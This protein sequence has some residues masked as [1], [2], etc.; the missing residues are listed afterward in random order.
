LGFGRQTLTAVI[1]FALLGP[2]EVRRDGDTL[3]L[4]GYKQRLLL[5]VLLLEANRAVASA[6]LIELLWGDDPPETASNI[7]QQYISQLRRLLDPQDGRHALV[8]QAPGYRLQVDSEQVDAARFE[9]LVTAARQAGTAGD[10]DTALRLYAEAETLWRGTLLA[11]LGDEPVVVRERTR[12]EELRLGAR[13]DRFEIGLRHGHHAD[14]V[15]AIETVAAEH[16]L[17]ER[18][19]GLLMRALYGSG[20]Q[21]EALAVYRETRRRLSD[22]LGI[23]PGP[24]L[25]KLELSVLRHDPL[26]AAPPQEARLDNRPLRATSRGA[27]S[28]A[29]CSSCGTEVQPGER[30]CPECAATLVVTAAAAREERKVITVLFADLVG[31]TSRSERMDPEDV[32]ALLSPY[33]TRV[34][35]ELERFGGTVEKFIGDAVMALFGAPVAH[36]DDPERAVRA[37]LAI[38]DWVVDEQADLQVRIAVNTGEALVTLGARPSQGEGMAS[39]DV[40]NT[41]ARLQTGAPVNGILVGETT[42]RATAPVITYRQPEPVTAKGKAEPVPAWE[43]LEARSRFGVDLAAASRSPLVGRQRELNVLKDALQRVRSDRAPQLVTLVGVPGIGKSRLVAELFEAVD[44]DPSALIFWRQGRSLPYGDGVTFWALAEMVKAQTGILETDSPEDAA[45]KLESSVAALIP[46]PADAQWIE[47]HLRPLAGLGSG[48]EANSDRREEA[49]TAWRRFFEALAEQSPLVLVFEDLHWAD[50]NLLDFVEHLVDWAGSVPLLVICTTRPELFERRPGWAGTSRTTTRL[51][52]APLSDDE[53]AQLIS[54]LSARPVMPAE[55]QQALL[56][57]AG[58][59]PLYAEQYVRML[60][61]R[62][63]AEDLP[64]PE[65]V[66]GIIAARLDALPAEEKRLL[67][68]A[69][70]LGK[71]FWLGAVT[72]GGE[73]ERRTAE[74]RLHVLERKDFVQ[75]ARRSSV[76][77][78]AE[79][80]FLHVLVRDVAYG[81]IPRGD[82][83]EKHRLAAEWIAALGRT[84]DHAEML[85]HHYLSAIQLRHAAGKSVDAPFAERALA[86]LRDAGE[87]AYS[88]DAYTGAAGYY[89]SALELATPGSS[90]RAQLLFKLG[91]TRRVA[92]DVGQELLVAARDALLAAGDNGVAAEAEIELALLNSDRGDFPLVS[93]CIGRARELVDNLE[94]SRSKAHVISAISGFLMI[95]GEDQAAIRVGRDALRMA[96]QLDLGEERAR[97]LS[98]IGSSRMK[99]GDYGGIDD[100]E[101][102]LAFALEAGSPFEICR[103]LLNVGYGFWVVGQLPRA[104]ASWQEAEDTALRFGQVALT[105]W[106]RS[107]RSEERY[108]LGEWEESLIRVNE[109][110]VEVEAGTPHLMAPTCYMTRAQIRL[111][112][113]DVPGA[114]ADAERALDRARMDKD[115]QG[116]ALALSAAMDVFREQGDLESAEVLAD[117][118]LGGLR[119][120]DYGVSDAIVRAHEVAWTFVALSRGQEWIEALPHTETPWLRAAILF[121]SGD[122]EGAANVCGAIGAATQEARDRLWLAEALIAQD[123]RAEADIQLQRALAFY[124]SVGATRYIREGEALLA[125]SA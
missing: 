52:L 91:R 102:S 17:R 99:R 70:V 39:G 69:A 118:L 117:E 40:V 122:L 24:E 79:Y 87:R 89:E 48:T 81:Q 63:D 51:S 60:S 64:L 54:S 21:A 108:V 29:S 84:E 78:E 121:M 53:T 80:A 86:S 26:I 4:G 22:E 83:A 10:D 59:N 67:Q 111:G 49:F 30:L 115:P 57:R 55:T 96:E 45:Q 36:E 125:V 116:L 58:G 37:A 11:D 104:S 85:A 98:V 90:E 66:Q 23:D 43:A 2:L 14:L 7:L 6:R 41:T 56:G 42:Y 109:L 28:T 38:R 77:N 106:I 15:A 5:G 62:G 93:G 92:G 100:L 75:R 13:E 61:E 95:A 105:R 76:A 124:R 46:D 18:L 16:P 110:L 12:M 68:D 71:V 103:S 20:R 8:S 112:R 101:R 107:M 44:S 47:A 27:M 113:D 88:L 119:S 120:R 33:Y 82:R 25:Q 32:R 73:P 114:I 3:R 94:L 97:A 19:Q 74:L 34:R 72:Q 9:H 123:R 31:F 50:D 35:T 1:E 65:T